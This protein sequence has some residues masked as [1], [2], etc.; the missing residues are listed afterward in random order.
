[1]AALL[2]LHDYEWLRAPL[3]PAPKSSAG[4]AHAEKEQGGGFGNLRRLIIE[5]Q[6]VDGMNRA[7]AAGTDQDL[8]RSDVLPRRP[9]E[10]DRPED[11]RCE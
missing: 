11:A 9:T 3:P 5:Y 6:I 10:Q 2:Y 7:L 1:M 4:Q 8:E